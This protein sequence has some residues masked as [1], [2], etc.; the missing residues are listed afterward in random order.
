M[1]SSFQKAASYAKNVQTRACQ[2][3]VQQCYFFL[4]KR[5]RRGRNLLIWRD[6]KL[7]WAK[8]R[9]SVCKQRRLFTWKD[10]SS[11]PSEPHRCTSDA[12]QHFASEQGN[13]RCS[14]DAEYE[15]FAVEPEFNCGWTAAE[16][17]NFARV[18]T[19]TRFGQRSS[20]AFPS[21]AVHKGQCVT[22][23][24]TFL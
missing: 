18:S 22:N 5:K 8:R 4:G 20:Q 14:A 21:N 6:K 3:E 16:S 17:T 9:S 1:L 2:M 10:T 11:V 15:E 12:D 13:P 24:S 23:G 19:N 7:Q